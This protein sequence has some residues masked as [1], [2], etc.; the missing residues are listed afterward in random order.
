MTRDFQHLRFFTLSTMSSAKDS[1]TLFLRIKIKVSQ[2]M[3]RKLCLCKQGLYK[4]DEWEKNKRN[5][6]ND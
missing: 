5:I 4:L 1:K 3:F 6:K 2:T